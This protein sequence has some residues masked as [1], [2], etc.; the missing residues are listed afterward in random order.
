MN[1]WAIFRCPFGTPAFGKLPSYTARFPYHRLLESPVNTVL[2]PSATEARSCTRKSTGWVPALAADAPVMLNWPLRSSFIGQVLTWQV[3][4]SRYQ[5]NRRMRAWARRKRVRDVA[6]SA[7]RNGGC[8]R[9]SATARNNP[10]WL[11]RHV[12]IDS[13]SLPCQVHHSFQSREER[14]G[15]CCARQISGAFRS[16]LPAQSARPRRCQFA[17]A[18]LRDMS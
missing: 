2:S 18:E 5:A 7:A 6:R 12:D 11:L 16:E 15:V 8:V 14:D 10:P 9:R 1:R 13:L 17:T 3:S 4:D